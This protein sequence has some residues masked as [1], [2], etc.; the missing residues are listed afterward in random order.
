MGERGVVGQLEA[1]GTRPWRAA[2]PTAPKP[3]TV[4]RRFT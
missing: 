4:T 1:V 2:T 3:S